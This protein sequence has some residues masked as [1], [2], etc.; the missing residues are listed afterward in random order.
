MSGIQTKLAIAFVV[1]TG[2]IYVLEYFLPA[3]QG[4]ALL[5]NMLFW[6]GIVEG[7]IAVIAVGEVT[8][9]RWVKPYRQ[10]L[11][12]VYP[13]IL[14]FGL[15]FIIFIPR[16]G[17]Y[18]WTEQPGF[19]LN[20]N[21]FIARHVIQ[22]IVVFFIARRFARESLNEGPRRAF[23]GVVYLLAFV[24]S[25]TGVAF[26]WLMS[27]EYPWFSTL[28]GGL[29]FIEAFYCGL[30]LAG[31]FT[32]FYREKFLSSFGEPFEKARMDMATLLFAF[33]IFWASQFYTQYLVIWYGDIPEEVSL[34][35]YRTLSSPMKEFFY[36][37]IAFNFIIPFITFTF[38]KMKANYLV[39]LI[40]SIVV[41]I[42]IA[43]E[44]LVIIV[45][46]LSINPLILIV[47][48]VII[49]LMMIYVIRKRDSFLVESS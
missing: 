29:F 17:H 5:F 34:I 1:V 24:I 28:F 16:L 49:G 8:N 30:A 39:F 4:G 18:P 36:S 45:P 14:L 48:F 41:W 33:A 26:D 6:I 10:E 12:S 15:L 37:V 31:M 43:V 2:L 19:W 25:M 46:R 9:G 42:G 47:E 44:R 23:W 21:L 13:L 22:L 3:G 27:L 38:R 35:Y 40:I 11:L 32:F 20:K 7:S